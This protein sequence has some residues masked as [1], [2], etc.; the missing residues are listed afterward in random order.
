MP[1]EFEQ[2]AI[3]EVVLVK[4]RVFGDTR[5]Y[6]L[7]GY[8]KSDFSSAG[9]DME[10]V[11]DNHSCSNLGVL[12]GIHYQLPPYAQAK[13]VRVVTGAVLDVAVD[14]RKSSPTFGKWVAHELSDENAK[15]LYIPEG[16]GHA[17]LTLQYNTHFLYKCSAEYSKSL[18][19]GVH[20]NDPHLN[21]SWPD[22]ELVVSDKDRNLPGLYEAE[23]FE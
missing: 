20:F 22:M 6:F 18:E 8:K 12:R 19:A 11:Q 3:P 9:I 4:P 1:F 2:T 5:G 23:V 21:I 14:L 15:M 17:F 16:F 10:F 7:E 13:L